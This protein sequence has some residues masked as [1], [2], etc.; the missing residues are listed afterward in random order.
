MLSLTTEDSFGGAWKS[1]IGCCRTYNRQE[2][3]PTCRGLGL[4]PNKELW[5]TVVHRLFRAGGISVH[6]VKA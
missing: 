5:F 3:L 1:R 6:L 2:L 4:M